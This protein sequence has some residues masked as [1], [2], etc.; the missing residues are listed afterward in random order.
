MLLDVT[1]LWWNIWDY[2][3]LIHN[4]SV[5]QPKMKQKHT[6]RLTWRKQSDKLFS[7]AHTLSD[8]KVIQPFSFDED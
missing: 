2:M 6:E 7:M 1:A 5:Y 3:N 4:Q 8:R